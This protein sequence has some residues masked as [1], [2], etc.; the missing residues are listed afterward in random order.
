MSI[1]I[2]SFLLTLAY[3]SF[4]TFLIRK[5]AGLPEVLVPENYNPQLPVSIIIPVRNEA[6]SIAICIQSIIDSNYPEELR[7]IIVI[8]DHSE[9]N[10]LNELEKFGAAIRVL[11]SPKE[12]YGKKAAIQLGIEM[13]EH[14]IVIQTDGDTRVGKDWLR[15]F[16]YCFEKMGSDFVTGPILYDLDKGIVKEFQC[17]ENLGTML[18]TAVGI[19]SKKYYLANGAN[20]AFRK[21]IFNNFKMDSKSM[22]YASGDDV[23]LIQHASKLANTR[24]DFLKS[25]NAVVKVKPENCLRDLYNQRLRWATK[26]KSYENN[27]L[28][29]ILTG[30]YLFS[31]SI[32][33]NLV[34]GLCLYPILLWVAVFQI[35]LKL[36]VD[37][38]LL[39]HSANFY[40]QKLGFIAFVRSFTFQYFYLL[41]MGLVSL[42]V[43]RFK[44]KGR[45]RS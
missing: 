27:R 18:M 14:P 3:V 43:R 44:W 20:M 25:N 23:F 36:V 6:N 34:L 17:V 8:N 9:D 10:T 35:L 1:L 21:E 41:V 29:I 5:W 42:I 13:A 28:K 30:V 33:I 19:G 38:S 24:I 32:L 11:Q 26:T 40:N 2:L 31:L 7:E 16:G 39:S 15:S 4:I 37:Y 45:I 12:V 22:K